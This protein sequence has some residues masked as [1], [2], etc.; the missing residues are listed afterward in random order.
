MIRG[1]ELLDGGSPVNEVEILIEKVD[2]ATDRTAVRDAIEVDRPTSPSDRIRKGLALYNVA[3]GGELISPLN[4]YLR[5]AQ[6][7]IQGGL[8]GRTGISALFIEVLW[9][10]ENLRRRGYGR[11]L[12]LSAEAEAVRRGCHFS[13]VDSYSFHAPAFDK[14]RGPGR[15]PTRATLNSA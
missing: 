6:H 15:P 4:V 12:V 8:L 3:N 9:I 14:R 1:C 7:E 2:V 13:H 5:D 10:A 11:E